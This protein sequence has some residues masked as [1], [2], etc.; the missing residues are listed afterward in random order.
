MRRKLKKNKITLIQHFKID[1]ASSH[2][3]DVIASY[4]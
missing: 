2:V 4:S 3:V 1:V